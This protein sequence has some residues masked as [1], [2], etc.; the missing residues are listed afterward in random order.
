[1]GG[2]D[3]PEHDKL[4][5]IQAESQAIGAFLDTGGYVLAQ[6]HQDDDDDTERLYPVGKGIDR[7]LADYFEIDLDVIEMEKRAMLNAIRSTS[8]RASQ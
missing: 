1:M 7:V 6:Y 3:Y 4:Q 5:K 8:I 2:L